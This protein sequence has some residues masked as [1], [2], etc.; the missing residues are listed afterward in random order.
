MA[1]TASGLY[2]K[3]FLDVFDASQEP[4]SLTG[5]SIKCALFTNSLTPNFSSDTAYVAS[6][7]TS[8]EISG[9][10]YTPGGTLLTTKTFSES[11]T[12]AVMF[13]SDDATWAAATFSNARGALIWDDTPT[14]PVA[15]PVIC[16]V[17]FGSDYGVTSGTFTV[18]WAGTGIFAIDLTP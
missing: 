6:P 12:G 1:I 17:N 18:Q 11:P 16:F 9:T 10:N 5:D 15:D 7:Y 2:V 14:T 8:N 3:T 13:D 4:I